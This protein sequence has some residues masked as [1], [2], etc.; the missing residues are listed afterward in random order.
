MEYAA[1]KSV[2]QAAALVSFTG[3]F[4][5]GL[6]VLLDAAWVRHPLT[7]TLPHLVDTVLL[8]S[9]LALAWQLAIDPRAAPWLMAKIVAL[10]V[11]IG[12][13][14]LALRPGRAKPVRAMAWLAALATFGY[15]VSVAFS[16]NPAGF[17][18]WLAP[19]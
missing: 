7:R 6:G 5:R 13:G 2:H 10:L 9:A 4:A 18:A 15:I 8:A 17:L 19:R 3:F 12:L 14:M 11:Y 1:L 16:K